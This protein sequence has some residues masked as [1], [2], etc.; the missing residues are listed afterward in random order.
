[1]CERLGIT[2]EDE[3][4]ERVRGFL[5]VIVPALALLEDGIPADIVPGP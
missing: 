2:P 5:D 3:D 4:L 1:M